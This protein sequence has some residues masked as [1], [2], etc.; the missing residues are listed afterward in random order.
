VN[1]EGNPVEGAFV[2]PTSFSTDYRYTKETRSWNAWNLLRLLGKKTDANGMVR[3]DTIPTEVYDMIPFM[4]FGD[5]PRFMKESKSKQFG[6]GRAVWRLRANNNELAISLPRRILI[7]GSVKNADGTVPSSMQMGVHGL[8]G[9]W[10]SCGT[11]IDYAGNFAFFVNAHEVISVQPIYN[12]HLDAK[13]G[14][15]P[16]RVNVPVGNGWSTP[17]P[18]FDFVL[19]KGTRV[20]GK[21]ISK[22]AKMD[23]SKTY[24]HVHDDTVDQ[25]TDMNQLFIDTNLNEQGE[26]NMLLP[27][28]RYRFKVQQ[29][30][31]G[32]KVEKVID[33]PLV[34]NG[35]EEI[36]FDLEI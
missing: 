13:S 21:L 12:P 1:H 26:I 15:A 31:D 28:G 7:E 5:D 18:R 23:Y 34:V 29:Y 16:A 8:A 2:A 6:E 17:A 4:A 19:E 14:V 3:F 24:I 35:E 20:T 11:D 10:S 27:K 9:G 25:M 33:K 32:K 30:I 22:D 36:R